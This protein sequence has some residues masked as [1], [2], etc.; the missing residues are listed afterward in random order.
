MYL[1]SFGQNKACVADILLCIKENDN[2]YTL[3]P[4]CILPILRKYVYHRICW[5]LAY[6]IQQHFYKE[7]LL[8]YQYRCKAIVWNI[9]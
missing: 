7:S 8:E 1:H 3:E 9:T 6:H 5:I 4:T 2:G